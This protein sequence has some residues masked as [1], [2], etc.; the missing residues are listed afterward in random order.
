M[1]KDQENNNSIF[2]TNQQQEGKNINSQEEIA[3]M[4]KYYW[5]DEVPPFMYT[6]DVRNADLHYNIL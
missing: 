1:K 6:E 4:A 3:A 5:T 2:P